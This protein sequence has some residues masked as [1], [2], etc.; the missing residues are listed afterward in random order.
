M[1]LLK[2]VA[3]M[4]QKEKRGEKSFL[5]G[6]IRSSGWWYFFLVALAVKTPLPLLILAAVGWLSVLWTSWVKRDWISAA[7]AIAAAAILLIVIPQNLSI[8]VR[9][10][11]AIYPLMA[12][13]GGRRRSQPLEFPRQQAVSRRAIAVALLAWQIVA[14]AGAHPDCLAYFN[15]LAGRRPEKIL[16]TSDLDWGQ[17]LLRLSST[18]KEKRVQFVSIA[19]SGQA[20]LKHVDLPPLR[21]LEPYEKATGWVGWHDAPLDGRHRPSERRLSVAERLSAVFGTSL[22]AC[23]ESCPGCKSVANPRAALGKL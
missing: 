22:T 3:Q 12:N 13:P 10:V 16:I 15:E 1:P 11:L 2:G 8:G 7:P 9:H 6:Q 19:Y 23:I 18:L 20:E 5:L 17:D 21:A 4:G 14:S